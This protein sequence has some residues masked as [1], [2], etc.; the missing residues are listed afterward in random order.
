MSANIGLLETAQAI[1]DSSPWTAEMARGQAKKILGRAAN[2]EDP[3]QEKQE[4][5]K[6]FSVAAL[7]DQYIL[8]G[9]ATKKASTLAT[10]RGR[11]ERHI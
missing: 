11:I 8:Q 9:C 6:Q 2:G 4:L 5:K 1:Q 10:D 3:A 7:C